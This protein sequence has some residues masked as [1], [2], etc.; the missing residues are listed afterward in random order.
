[1]SEQVAKNF[2][3]ALEKLEAENDLE[4]IVSLFRKLSGQQ[5]GISERISGNR[6]RS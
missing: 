4:T 1:M 5:C 2:I 3:K 6:G